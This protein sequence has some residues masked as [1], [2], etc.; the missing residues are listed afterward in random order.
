VAVA[1]QMQVFDAAA[2]QVAGVR[3]S[4]QTS[5]RQIPLPLEVI[6]VSQVQTDGS[7]WQFWLDVDEAQALKEQFFVLAV[8]EQRD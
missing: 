5:G 1:S 7:S 6:D 3:N 4:E 8:Q 2:A